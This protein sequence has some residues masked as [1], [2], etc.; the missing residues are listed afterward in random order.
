MRSNILRYL[1][2]IAVS[3][4]VSGC[5]V[6]SVAGAAVTVAGAAVSVGVAAGSAAVGVATTVAK[7][8]VS[9][10]GAVVESVTE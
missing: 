10:G 6:V 3:L 4:T 2:C 1:G 5:A 8:V 7:G 9:A